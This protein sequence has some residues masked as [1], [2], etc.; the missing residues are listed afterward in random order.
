MGGA[1]ELSNCRVHI[2]RP[3]NEEPAFLPFLPIFFLLAFAADVPFL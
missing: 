1:D 3:L 2:W